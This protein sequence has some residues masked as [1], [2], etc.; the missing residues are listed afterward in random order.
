ML[1]DG[2][3]GKKKKKNGY[4]G[5]DSL[6]TWKTNSENGHYMLENIRILNWSFP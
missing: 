2:C 1:M 5:K 6:T 3:Q 4:L